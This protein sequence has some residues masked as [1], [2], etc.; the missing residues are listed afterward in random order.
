MLSFPLFDGL[1]DIRKPENLRVAIRDGEDVEDTGFPAWAKVRGD[2][3]S[4]IKLQV[5]WLKIYLS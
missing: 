4:L 1:G 3:I 5:I 2:F